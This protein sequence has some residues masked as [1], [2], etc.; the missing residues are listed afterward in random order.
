MRKKREMRWTAGDEVLLRLLGKAVE[1]AF[2]ALPDEI[3]YTPRTLG[4]SARSRRDPRRRSLVEAPGFMDR[5][6]TAAECRCTMRRDGET[7]ASSNA[8]DRSSTPRFPSPA[9]VPPADAGPPPEP[10]NP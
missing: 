5:P 6:K 1:V 10:E 7:R 4:V 8:P 9:C 3:G 2:W